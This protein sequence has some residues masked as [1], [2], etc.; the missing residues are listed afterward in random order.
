MMFYVIL[1]STFKTVYSP[2]EWVYILQTGRGIKLIYMKKETHNPY[3]PQWD[4][5]WSIVF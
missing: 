1:C 5:E 3:E 2:P 4:T